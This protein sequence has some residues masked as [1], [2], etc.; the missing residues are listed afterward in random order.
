MQRRGCDMIED[1][2]IYISYGNVNNPYRVRRAFKYFL[3]FKKYDYILRNNWTGLGSR[4]GKLKS[5]VDRA[6]RLANYNAAKFAGKGNRYH[7]KVG[8]LESKTMLFLEVYKE[9]NV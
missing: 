5:V 6:L 1:Y 9:S 8:K 4:R 3:I 7:L 2:R